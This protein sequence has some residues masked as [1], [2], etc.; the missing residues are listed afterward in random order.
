MLKILL[1]IITLT[2]AFDATSA[3]QITGIFNY[4]TPPYQQLTITR[5]TANKQYS[6]CAVLPN[7]V[8]PYWK[9][10]NEHFSE[11]SEQYGIKITI[12]NPRGYDHSEIQDR[13][14]TDRCLRLNAD[15]IILATSTPT[16]LSSKTLDLLQANQVPV[17]DFMNGK[18]SGMS[19]AIIHIPF[20]LLGK[21][22]ASAITAEATNKHRILWLPG[23]AESDWSIQSKQ[24][25]TSHFKSSEAHEITTIFGTPFYR[26]S[27]ILL[28]EQQ[29]SRFDIIAG[30]APAIYAAATLKEENSSDVKLY[31]SYYN[32]QLFRYI[33][34]GTVSASMY[35]DSYTAALL[36]IDTMIKILNDEPY[37]PDTGPEIE[38]MTPD[39]IDS[40][41]LTEPQPEISCID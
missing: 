15:G 17:I 26:Q 11:L 35:F 36:A 41:G 31:S 40:F 4:S 24:G 7:S 27:L 29:D 19:K 16:S 37:H 13:L 14:I 22:L 5:S 20:D 6:L 25:F 8:D 1:S 18:S 33:K 10:V 30:N 3:E 2:I 39:N 9:E 28:K 34:C 23:P 21:K 38:I 32:H 12:F